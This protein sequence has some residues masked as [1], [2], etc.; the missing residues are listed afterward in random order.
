MAH[1]VERRGKAGKSIPKTPTWMEHSQSPAAMADRTRKVWGSTM[2]WARH[3]CSATTGWLP[4]WFLV[5]LSLLVTGCRGLPGQT[6]PIT[7]PFEENLVGKTIRF[8]GFVVE[9]VDD[10]FD[11]PHWLVVRVDD[12]EVVVVYSLVTYPSCA[13]EQ[14]LEVAAK[15]EPRDRVEVFGQVIEA[16]GAVSV[17]GSPEH[18]LRKIGR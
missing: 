9:K 5:L 8:E 15:I 3:R 14:V 16:A 12:Q 10:I 2:A 1:K 4:L 18:Y 6:T 13:N 17:C 11:L 7:L